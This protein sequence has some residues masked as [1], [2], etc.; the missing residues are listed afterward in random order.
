VS[1]DDEKA[2]AKLVTS[3]IKLPAQPQVLLDLQK[4]LASDNYSVRSLANIIGQ[5]PGLVAMVFKAARSPVFGRGKKIDNLEQVLMVIGVKQTYNLVQAVALASAVSDSSRK[6][7]DIFW[8]RSREIAQ[9]SAIIAADRV[10]VCNVFP[11]QAYMAGIFHECGVPVLMLRFPKYCGALHLNDV[12]CWP[13]LA[14]EDAKFDVDHCSVGYLVARHWNLPEFVCT[15][16]RYH[17]EMPH[18]EMGAS[19]ALVANLQL[20]IHF[21]HGM[22]NVPDPLWDR[23][24]L[25]V[26]KEVGIHPDEERDYGEEI[27][28]QFHGA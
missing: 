6:A 23:I 14:E 22:N 10:S 9:L 17:H 1:S 24:G 25:E 8:T 13:N 19:R 16:I 26:L 2:L 18:D 15:A 12:C 20:A 11:D 21:Y 7:F 3:G 5:D 28:D 4:S 27:L